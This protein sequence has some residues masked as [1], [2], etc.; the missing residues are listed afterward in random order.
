MPPLILFG[1]VAVALAYRRFKNNVDSENLASL[2]GEFCLLKFAGMGG[3]AHARRPSRL[4]H[5]WHELC[6]NSGY[7]SD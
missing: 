5:C 4:P 1:D 2:L 7:A 6:I 3:R